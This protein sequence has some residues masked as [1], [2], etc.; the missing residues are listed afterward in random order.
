MRFVANPGN[1]DDSLMLIPGG[2]SG[3]LGSSHYSDQFRYWYEGTPI[4][5]P[6]SDSAQS[7]TRKHTLT[8]KP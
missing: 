5:A 3:Q 7:A 4:V 1:W 2:Q 8:L 6:F